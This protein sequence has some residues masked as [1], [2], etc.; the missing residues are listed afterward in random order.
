M[1]ILSYTTS[2]S[3]DGYIADA[4][5][6][7]QW[8]AP[9]ADVFALHLA[10]MAEVSTE[11]MG[12]KTYE[13]MRFWETYPDGEEAIPGEREFASRW[14]DI[15]KVVVSSTLTPAELGPEPVRLIPELGLDELRQI[16][17]SAPGHVEI[18]G[19]TTA[20]A[21]IRAGMVEDFR[22]FVVPKMVGGGLRAL[23]DDVH[24]DL[25]LAEHRTFADGT[26][27]QRYLRH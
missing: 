12:R 25:R 4:A 21:A 20:A 9:D 11:V 26:T 1:G 16:V 7:F 18:F 27:Y 10:R 14:K 13:L 22:F 19:P 23:P 2:V 6:D 8:G 15:D 24:F 3:I 5:G 17:D